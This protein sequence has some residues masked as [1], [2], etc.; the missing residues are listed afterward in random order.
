M[1]ISRT[2]LRISFLGGGTDYPEYV[3]ANGWGAVLGTTIDKYVYCSASK[4]YSDLFDHSIRLSYRDIERVSSV[5]QIRHQPI[6]RCLEHAGI[7]NDVEISNAAELPAYSGLGSSSSFVVGLLHALYSLRG[8]QVGAA[9]LAYEA[10]HVERDLLGDNVGL[11]DQ[12]LAA[13]GGTCLVTFMGKSDIRVR[14]LDLGGPAVEALDSHLALF[15][16]GIQRRASTVIAKQLARVKDNTE[17][18]GRMREMAKQ[19]AALL[20]S[21]EGGRGLDEFGALVGRGWDLKKSLDPMV[22]SDQINDMYERGI[23][24]GAYGGKL[25]GAGA[26]GFL[27]FVVAPGRREELRSALEGFVEIPVRTNSGGSKVIEGFA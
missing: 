14:R 2:P 7:S 15:F 1:I 23:K 21:A 9:Q 11:Q 13:H 27:L 10:I 26:G 22:S 4:F 17:A 6:R 24:A 5:D 12:T 19:G 3:D 18:L 25:L 8:R 16:T 20:E